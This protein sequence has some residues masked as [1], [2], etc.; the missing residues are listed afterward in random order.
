MDVNA[1]T[2]TRRSQLTRPKWARCLF[3]LL[4]MGSSAA[5][6]T[7]ASYTVR[8][9]DVPEWGMRALLEDRCETYA[10]QKY[11][12]PTEML[13]RRRAEQDLPAVRAVLQSAGYY[14]AEPTAD[15]VTTTPRR[16]VFHLNPGPRYRVGELSVNAAP[17]ELPRLR[18]FG[19]KRG[20]PARAAALL[21]TEAECLAYVRA[22]GYPFP[23][24]TSRLYTPD[25]E[26]HALDVNLTLDPGE[27]AVWGETS[28]TGLVRVTEGFVRNE[29]ALPAGSPFKPA[30]VIETQ[31]RLIRLGLFSAVN[32]TP[33]DAMDEDGRLPL[34]LSLR[35]R[36]PRT[37]SA[38]VRY[39]TDEGYGARVEWEHRN[40]FSR[41]ERLRLAV[42]VGETLYAAEARFTIPQFRQPRQKLTFS[43]RA[44]DESPGAYESR[45]VRGLA[46]LE[47]EWRQ[48]FWLRAGT[49]FRLS[50]V[51]QFDEDNNYIFLTFPLDADWNT[52]GNPLDPRRGHRLLAHV[53][54]FYDLETMDR[55]FVKS[56][57]TLNRYQRLTRDRT[58]LL[59][60]RVTAGSIVGQGERSVP[61]DE[62]FYAGGGSSV[63]GY[64]YQSVGPLKDGDPLGGRSLI[65]TSVEL[66]AHV[67]ETLGFV[68]FLD[69][70]AAFT[71]ATP[72]FSETLRW[73]TGVGLRYFTP[74][75]PLRAD[76]GFPLDRR[77]DIDKSYQFYLSLGQSF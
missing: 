57:V 63:R 18:T 3:L 59:A 33:A 9:R 76:I 56:A 52:S 74:V 26:R 41:A 4:W 19:W 70:G 60:G 10:L 65:E 40:L 45:S 61:A 50:A 69:G 25:H 75:G 21:A 13:L 64:A 39:T 72:D 77:P 71:T 53:E 27:H 42:D 30:Q 16:V 31:T 36:R 32:L 2:W 1:Q 17:V 22:Q 29:L 23:R 51:D 35:E 5:A 38:G 55:A 73:G 68:L 54:P 67:T 46:Q 58:W 43:A 11:P 66:R 8:F 20:E 15:V 48:V 7:P 44:A 24:W 6:E 62:R 47:R 12:P 34:T 14:G 28:I 37:I 49:G